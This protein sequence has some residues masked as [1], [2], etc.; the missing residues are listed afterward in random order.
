M[1]TLF[2]IRQ[3]LT[4]IQIFSDQEKNIDKVQK[5]LIQTV[6]YT[7]GLPSMEM[8]VQMEMMLVLG[9][10]KWAK[11]HKSLLLL[12]PSLNGQCFL[13]QSPLADKLRHHE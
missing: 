12:A 10:A 8:S 1:E 6:Q 13:I 9:P 5:A 2:S 11:C 4:V 3:V 7:Y